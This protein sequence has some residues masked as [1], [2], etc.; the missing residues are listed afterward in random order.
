MSS[1]MNDRVFSQG[2]SQIQQKQRLLQNAAIQKLLIQYI[3][4]TETSK[5]FPEFEEWMDFDAWNP[6]AT[7]KDFKTIDKR[8]KDKGRS[9][10]TETE[11]SEE[12]VEIV[13][14]EKLE[15][16]GEIY[17]RKNPELSSRTLLGLKL[18]I[19]KQDTVDTILRKVRAAFSDLSLADEAL[20]FLIESGEEEII[21]LLKAAKEELRKN[22]NREIVAGKNIAS[23]ARSYA[24]EGIGSSTTLRNLY[25]EITGN[26]RDAHTLFEELTTNY[27]FEKMKTVIDFVLHSLGADVN[28]KGPSIDSKELLRLMDETRNMQAI[29]GVY[30]YF[31]SRSRL[32]ITSFQRQNLEIPPK[33]SFE[34]LA[35]LFMQFIQE[36][37]PSVK[38]ALS[39]SRSLGIEHQIIPQLIIY[40][41]YRDAIRQVSPRLFKDDKHRQEILLCFM[42]T[43]E[44]LEEEMEEEKEK[45]EDE[46]K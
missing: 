10:T 12:E 27:P 18:R 8:I 5:E 25:R 4:T 14:V 17:E 6:L 20:D 41:Q 21:P 46:E 45:D 38:K 30:R 1:E 28:S 24:S 15:S 29:L 9:E 39:L 40:F 37:Y 3:F 26:P 31:A 42:E 22:Y 33:I 43:L 23:E 32:I 2:A 7:S 13:P 16:I 36:R 44:E 34:L 19:S 35:K 11:N